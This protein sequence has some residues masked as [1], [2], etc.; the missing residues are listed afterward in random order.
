MG[1]SGPEI[2]SWGARSTGMGGTDIAVA[3]DTFAMATNPAGLTQ[4]EGKRF[5]LGV[6]SFN[7]WTE[8]KN[9]WNYKISYRADYFEY[10]IP[11]TGY[12]QR[13]KNTNLTLGIGIYGTGGAGCTSYINTP[14]FGKVKN[15][16]TIGIAKITPALALQINPRLSLGIALNINYAI[17]DISKLAIGPAYLKL[18]ELDGWG[19]GFSTGI[20]YQVTDKL[21]LGLSY[22][23][24]TNLQDLESSGKGTMEVS[25][26]IP[27]SQGGGS[28]IQYSRS[29]VIDYQMP[30]KLGLGVSYKFS[31]QLLLAFDAKWYDLQQSAEKLALRLYREDGS[32]QTLSLP[33]N[34]HNI[35]ILAMGIE[36]RVT[37]NTALR[38]GYSYFTKTTDNNNIGHVV[39]FINDMHNITW[40]ISHR[41]NSFE[42]GFAHSH[43]FRSVNRN[44]TKEGEFPA[45]EYDRSTVYFGDNYFVLTASWLF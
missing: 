34:C 13:L 29:K 44:K 32:N 21:S 12:A 1:V 23:S 26:L 35:F 28:I 24:E 2:M 17:F 18:G 6:G 43:G 22:T 25:S 39:A 8:L 5:D 27:P 33:L 10:P 37:E 20:L 15:Y 31:R 36:Y 16:S 4:I 42:L 45:P 9:E 38:M 7:P 3:T 40:G 30:Q 19:Y 41:W 11:Q 14:F